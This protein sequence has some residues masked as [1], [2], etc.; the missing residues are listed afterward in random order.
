M[1]VYMY[2]CMYVCLSVFCCLSVCVFQLSV[3]PSSIC[4]SVVCLPSVCISVCI[5]LIHLDEVKFS[6][7]KLNLAGYQHAHLFYLVVI[8]DAS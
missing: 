7:D 3:C 2:V 4:L 5:Y 1:C 6:L 8:I